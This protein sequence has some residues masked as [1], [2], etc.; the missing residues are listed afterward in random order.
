LYLSKTRSC[1]PYE[2]FSI[3]DSSLD[4]IFK[5]VVQWVGT[6]PDCRARAN[7]S[8]RRP[9]MTRLF[10][11]TSIKNMVQANRFVRSATWEGM[12]A[13]DG[14]VTP[15]LIDVQIQLA[16]G[17]IGLI[18]SGHAYVSRKGQA[19]N[20]QLGVYSDV[21]IPGLTAMADAVHA[22]GG[23]IALQLA[24]AGSRGAFQISGLEPMGP[25]VMETDSGPTGREMTIEDIEEITQVF[26]HAAARAQT[27]GFDA[28]QIHAAHGYLLSQYLSP[29]FNKRKD[30]YGGSIEN[31]ARLLVQVLKAIRKEV[32]PEFP[33]FTKLNS[34]DFL[35]GGLMVEDMVHTATLLEEA[36][37]DAI[38]LSGGTFLSGK[39]SPSRKGKPEPGEPEAY[40]E[41][42]AG[43]YKKEISVP[44]MLVGGIRTIETAERLI[45]LEVADYVSLCRPLIREPAL[46]N[47]WKS[48]DRRPALCVSDSG[49][50][51]PGFEG[52][53]VYCVVEEREK[54]RAGRDLRTE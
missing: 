31:R 48:G 54:Q 44:L 40:Y 51:A 49:C 11:S 33:V 52:K 26:A 4:S 46:I 16:R 43:K 12:A 32:G 3:S 45:A 24:H 14:A 38:E 22:V 18:I 37:I 30:D 29:F 47:R 8:G 1:E 21:L 2:H 36:G 19:G 25:S 35:P 5:K 50:F 13:D 42:A 20:Q 28:V 23:K 27:A 39:N 15:R 9:Q 10:E 53:G 6:T 34:E 41:V 7:I 17:G